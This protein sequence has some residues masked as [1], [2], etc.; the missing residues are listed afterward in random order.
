MKS[1]WQSKFTELITRIFLERPPNVDENSFAA[2]VV[3]NIVTIFGTANHIGYLFLFW[4][5]DVNVLALFNII[6]ILMWALSFYFCRK[7]SHFLSVTVMVI[8]L[9][10]HQILCVIFIGWGA[11]LF[12]K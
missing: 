12:F 9:L 5:L 6:S 2:F 1:L 10:L 8:E 4:F 11:D 3:F 7:G